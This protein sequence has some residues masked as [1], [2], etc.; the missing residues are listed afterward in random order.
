M[1]WR[2]I[3]FDTDAQLTDIFYKEIKLA[4]LHAYTNEKLPLTN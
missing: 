1:L 2:D 4:F 3:R